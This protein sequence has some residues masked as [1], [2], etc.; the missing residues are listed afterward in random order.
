MQ[1]NWLKYVQILTCVRVQYY[2]IKL[3]QLA[4]FATQTS[5]IHMAWVL[6]PLHAHGFRSAG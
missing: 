1:T 3:M 2:L 4:S 6:V 5:Q